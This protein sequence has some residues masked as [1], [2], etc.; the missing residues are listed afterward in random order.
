MPSVALLLDTGFF[1]SA[2]LPFI[3]KKNL[4]D[5]LV[6]LRTE[7][8]LTQEIMDQSVSLSLLVFDLILNLESSNVTFVKLLWPLTA[9][10]RMW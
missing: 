5:L 3:C 4:V 8:I 7:L 2:S 6:V 10:S 1:R 9:L